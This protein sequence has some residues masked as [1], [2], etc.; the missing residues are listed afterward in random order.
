[1][2]PGAEIHGEIIESNVGAGVEFTLYPNG[3]LTALT[4]AA[5]QRVYIT[6]LYITSDLANN[7]KVTANTDDAGERVVYERLSA[8]GGAAVNF[9]HP[10]LCPAG[11]VPKVWNVG[12][13]VVTAIMQ[14]TIVEV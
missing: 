12:P 10:Y 11:V 4:L 5:N 3:S 6:D 14:G 1:M 2:I 9:D 8:N 13:A 7:V